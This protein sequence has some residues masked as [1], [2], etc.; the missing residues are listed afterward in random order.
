MAF[1][2]IGR[3]PIAGPQTRND[4][5]R[6]INLARWRP[7]W[8][9]GFAPV[10]LSGDCAASRTRVAACVII[11]TVIRSFT[12]RATEDESAVSALNGAHYSKGN[13][14][15]FP[16]AISL[17]LQNAFANRIC[18]GVLQSATNSRGLATTTARHLARDVATFSRFGL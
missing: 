16:P 12:D 11:H 18:S 7:V 3:V 5:W 14:D 9:L 6:D 13:H 8:L 1:Y 17:N 10:L 4:R 15:S 2:D